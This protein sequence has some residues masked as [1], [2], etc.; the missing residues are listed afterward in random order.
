M[1]TLTFPKSE[2]LRLQALVDPLFREGK[3]LFEYPLRL[4]YRP[5]TADELEGSFR[6][7]VPA[8]IA[9]LQVMITVPKKKR[10]HAVDRVLMR[11][12]IR[13]GW[14]LQ[15]RKL[16]EAVEQDPGLRTLSV[17]IIYAADT[18]I[19]SARIHG[20]IDRLITKLINRLNPPADDN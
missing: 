6:I 10:R 11:R 5:L 19:D 3:S 14:R 4:V 17:A 15:R 8:G 12:R 13:E 7:G 1:T 20:K 18:N 9:P 16:R 2:R